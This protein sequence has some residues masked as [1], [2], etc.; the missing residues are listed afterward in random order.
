M[1]QY[2]NAGDPSALQLVLL[3]NGKLILFSFYKFNWLLLRLWTDQETKPDEDY[4]YIFAY[5][6]TR[7]FMTQSYFLFSIGGIMAEVKDI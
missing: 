6:I 1:P 7:H 3:A 2:E 5:A 4:I